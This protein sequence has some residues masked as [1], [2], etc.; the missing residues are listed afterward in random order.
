MLIIDCDTHFGRHASSSEDASLERLISAEKGESVDYVMAYSLTARAYD[1]CIGNDMTLKASRDHGEV[2]PLATVD[3]RAYYGVEDEIARVAGLGFVGLRVFPEL[4]GWSLDSLLFSRIIECCQMHELP[5]F[6]SADS[7]GKASAIARAAAKSSCKI[8]LLNANYAVQ[9]EALTALEMQP[10]LYLGTRFFCTPGA[11][12]EAVARLGAERFVV[13]TDAPACGIRES[14]SSVIRSRLADKDKAAILGGNTLRLIDGQLRKLGKNLTDGGMEAYERKCAT[15]SI[16]DVHGHLGSWP[17]PMRNCD[18]RDLVDLMKRRGI[19]KCVLSSTNAIVNDFVD[20]NAELD[21][22]MDSVDGI[23]G[24]VTLNPN[25]LEESI[26]QMRKYLGKPRFV[27]LKVHPGY[28]RAAI[29]GEAMRELTRVAVALGPVPFLIHTM[30][31]GEPAKIGRLAKEFPEAPI[32]MAHGGGAAWQEALEVVKQT[33][34][35]YVEFCSSR[36]ELGK[37]RRAI[38]EV[39]ADR[40]LFGTDLGLFDPAYNLG[41]YESADLTIAEQAAIMRDN[42]LKLFSFG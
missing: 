10:N 41:T 31:A 37:V 11:Y 7:P 24:Y 29:D 22:A 17:L 1:A 9:A 20:G 15:T 21:A 40:I 26:A 38:G 28:A 2:L 14:L 30:G 8:V 35:T 27:G 16:I 39:G 34:N 12:E 6:V 42:A 18:A 33:K 32:I 19:E 36:C 13:G 5:L 3:P 4:Q 23:Y 25:Y